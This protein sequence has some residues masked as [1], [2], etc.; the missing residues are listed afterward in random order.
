MWHSRQKKG[1]EEEGTRKRGQRWIS[2][3][4]QENILLYCPSGGFNYFFLSFLSIPPFSSRNCL[5]TS[6]SFFK[7][8]VLERL[9]NNIHFIK[10]QCKPFP[11]LQHKKKYHEKHLRCAKAVIDWF[12]ASHFRAASERCLKKIIIKRKLPARF[13]ALGLLIIW[14][15]KKSWKKSRP[16]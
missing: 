12:L 3:R 13:D 14:K 8:S 1:G 5:N 11:G 7:L 15:E 2:I 4:C 6:H 16:A 10:Y 9:K